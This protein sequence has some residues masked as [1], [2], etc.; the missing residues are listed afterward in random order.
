[1][2]P[3]AP[4]AHAYIRTHAFFWEESC[5]CFRNNYIFPDFNFEKIQLL[6]SNALIINSILF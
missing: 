4:P 1:M 5:A 6:W 3:L 2:V